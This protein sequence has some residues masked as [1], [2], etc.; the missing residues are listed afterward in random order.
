MY[1]PLDFDLLV[2]LIICMLIYAWLANLFISSHN[3]LDLKFGLPYSCLP[4]SAEFNFSQKEK[5]IFLILSFDLC[6]AL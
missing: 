6:F 5:G 1:V 2:K 3:V 4:P